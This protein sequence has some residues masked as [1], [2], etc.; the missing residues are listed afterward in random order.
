[1]PQK[2]ATQF[3]IEQENAALV[4]GLC[5]HGLAITRS[6]SRLGVEVHAIESNREL[7]GTRTNTARVHLV[8]DITLNNLTNTLIKVKKEFLPKKNTV[9]FLTS[10]DHVRAVVKHIDEITKNFSLSWRDSAHDVARLILKENLEKHCH[11]RKLNY[12]KSAI[13][14]N[15]EKTTQSLAS[16]RLP[17]ILKP[18][19][20]LS[21]FKAETF[22]SRE[23]A[24]RHIE[25]NTDDLPILAQEYITGNDQCIFFTAL[26]LTKGNVVEHFSGK[27][28]KSHPPAEGQT[29]I[30]IS[31]NNDEALTTSKIFFS[32]T[33]LS[34]P[35][36]LEIKKDHKGKIWVIE[37]TLGRTDFWVNLSIKS[38]KDLI[39]TQYQEQT[40]VKM[41]NKKSKHN[42]TIWFD[43]ERDPIST[44]VTAPYYYIFKGYQPIFSFLDK[45]DIKP[46]VK[47]LNNHTKRAITFIKKRLGITKKK[48]NITKEK[49][50]HCI[51]ETRHENTSDIF[52]SRSWYKIF[53]THVATQYGES[54]FYTV[55]T[56]KNTESIVPM[57]KKTCGKWPTKFKR[58]DSLSNYYSPTYNIIKGTE[59]TLKDV[60]IHIQ[61]TENWSSININPITLEQAK[62]IQDTAKSIG[63]STHIYNKTKNIFQSNIINFEYFRDGL[64]RRIINTISRKTRKLN[65]ESKWSIN[66]TKNNKDT[67][68]FYET[69]NNI[70]LSSWKK[71]EPHKNFIKELLREASRMG[72]LLTGTITINQKP[73]A[74]QIW[75]INN[76]TAYIYKLSYAEEHKTSSPGTL[77]TYDMAKYAITH[78]KVE[79]IDFL[80][81]NEKFKKEWLHQERDLY[82]IELTN[83]HSLIGLAIQIKNKLKEG[84]QVITRH[85]TQ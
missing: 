48:S 36:S 40:K 42:K 32:G 11:E 13:I 65:R 2:T 22:H 76:N 33:T 75:L 83:K 50:Y 43:S 82:G 81:G 74:A 66:I 71:S 79:R 28:I 8:D 47:S 39:S 4:V 29:T 30:A 37:P 23:L 5:S 84:K 17:I 12:P 38:K 67:D 31:D 55:K 85:E 25:L 58:I 1:M 60:L 80:N 54:I 52:S 51:K 44:I 14:K 49:D 57:I 34:G 7:P 46:S 20:P 6:L 63:I 3:I 26:Y 15:I 69:Y 10:D 35:A 45:N 62:E 21:S 77:L 78:E 73:A 61:Q 18:S 64:S 56:A 41:I 72:W 68:S 59:S 70:Y 16:L 53:T 24:T 27:K 9:L 19:V